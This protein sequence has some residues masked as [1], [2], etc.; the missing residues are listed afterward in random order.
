MFTDAPN[1]ASETRLF[2]NGS[3]DTRFEV[4]GVLR[5]N[6]SVSTG[7]FD[8]GSVPISAQLH[9]ASNTKKTVDADIMSRRTLCGW[10]TMRPWSDATESLLLCAVW[11][12]PHTALFYNTPR[13]CGL[14]LLLSAFP[15]VPLPEVLFCMRRGSETKI[16]GKT[17]GFRNETHRV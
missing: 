6:L 9:C 2:K 13:I 16:A 4:D 17:G 7:V 10:M 3:S 11:N 8:M 5:Q 15:P 12:C 1:F 14:F